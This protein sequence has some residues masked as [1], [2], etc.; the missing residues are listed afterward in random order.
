M[1]CVFQLTLWREG[2]DTGSVG[3]DLGNGTEYG[4]MDL[5][6]QMLRR[7]RVQNWHSRIALEMPQ[8]S[9]FQ[10]LSDNNL[11]FWHDI[12]ATAPKVVPLHPSDC[13]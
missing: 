9:C 3:F 4:S 5:I 6:S 7:R 8:H 2:S 10:N 13:W 1:N 12:L 11:G